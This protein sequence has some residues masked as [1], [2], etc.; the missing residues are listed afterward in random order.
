MQFVQLGRPTRAQGEFGVSY[1]MGKPVAELIAERLPATLEL[2]CSRRVL[3]LLV[4]VPMGVYT[5]L[6]RDSWL[7]RVFLTVSLIGISLPTFL[8]G[9]LLILIF[10]VWL[11]W[12]PTF[13]RGG[14]VDLGGWETELPDAPGLEPL[15]MPAITLGAVPAD[16]DHAAGARRDAGGAAHRL[17]QVRARPG[18]A[19]TAPST[20][21]TRSRTRWCR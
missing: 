10:G 1:R 5:G 2:V 18:P 12:L 19:R 4:G 14:T 17:H 21:A 11:G 3:A 20:S 16:P 13:G 6:H 7:R 8:I 15:I 9:I